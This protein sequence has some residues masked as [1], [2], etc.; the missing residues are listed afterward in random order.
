MGWKSNISIRRV[1]L[2]GFQNTLYRNNIKHN[3]IGRYHIN[4]YLG[5]KSINI[6]DINNNKDNENDDIDKKLNKSNKALKNTSK[7]TIY[8]ELSKARLSALVVCTTGAGFMVAG[9]PFD[10]LVMSG[11]CIGTALCAASANTFNQVIEINYDK[12]MNR[13]KARPLPSGRVTK[14]EAILWGLTS[15]TAGGTLLYVTANPLVTALGVGNIALYAGV[16]TALKRRSELNTWV[17]SIVGAIPP[18]MGYLAAIDGNYINMFDGEALS[19]AALLFYW[20]FPHFF[21]LSY[22]HR[23]D[24]SRGGFQM[25][26]CNEDSGR[27]SADLVWKYSVALSLLPTAIWATNVASSMV[28]VESIPVNMYL[29]Y[30]A[31]KFKSEGGQTNGN[32]KRVFL[33]SL[34]YLP[35]LMFSIILHS[36]NWDKDEN[37]ER[38]EHGVRINAVEE[39]DFFQTHMRLM[40]DELKKMCVHE[41]ARPNQNVVLKEDILCPKTMVD[42]TVGKA[43]EI[44]LPN[45]NENVNGS[46]ISPS[47][48]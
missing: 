4:R 13:T 48:K 45:V 27:R 26:A 31:H 18:V 32:A 35:L 36:K 37:K 38:I 14:N 8:K 30:L 23:E 39:H 15:A 6:N 34:I 10:W 43:K 20:Q 1:Y 12:M 25:V 7:M 33:Y 17:G 44:L 28:I 24:Y 42:A 29:L 2:R 19:L 9:P 11:T 22:L 40:R 5:T 3:N 47:R 41:L 21:A 16:Y 46:K